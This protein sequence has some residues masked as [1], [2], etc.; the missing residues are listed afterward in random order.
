MKLL[1]AF[2][3]LYAAVVSANNDY[4]LLNQVGFLHAKVFSTTDETLTIQTISSADFLGNFSEI[5]ENVYLKPEPTYWYVIDLDT[6]DLEVTDQWYLS[7]TYYDEI[8]LY[9]RGN[10]KID[11]VRAGLRT[12]RD[13]SVKD[14]SDIPFQKTQ[15]FNGRYLYAKVKNYNNRYFINDVALQNQFS[16]N[17][18]KNH[19][20]VTEAKWQIKYYLFI[21]GAT[22]LF[23]YFI[24]IYFLYRDRLYII[25]S[26]YLFS[27]LLYIGAKAPVVSQVIRDFAPHYFFFYNSVIQIIVNILYLSFSIRFLNSKAEYPVLH[28]IFR[29]TLYFLYVVGIIQ[30]VLFLVNPISGWEERILVVERYYMLIFSLGSLFTLL[31]I[32]KKKQ[33]LFFVAGGFSFIIGAG[34]AFLLNNIVYM[35]IGAGLELFMFSIG[36]G[37][38]M[39]KIE[40]EKKQI[41]NEIVKVELSA[42]K[43]QMNPHFIF[44]SLNSIRAYVIANETKKASDYITKFSKLIRLML[45][46]SSKENIKLKEEI[47]ALQL[48]VQLEE[49]RFREGFGFKVTVDDELDTEDV[50]LPPLILQPY[51]ENAI[52]HGLAP[53]E[54]EKNIYLTITKRDAIIEFRIK[55]NGVGRQF[56]QRNIANRMEHKSIA[57]EL[58][59][60]RIHLTEKLYSSEENIIVN[61]LMENGIPA[62]TEVIIRLTLLH[63][64]KHK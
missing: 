25:Y 5:P 19:I 52:R 48:Y 17:F 40:D 61:D 51:I 39:K 28:K 44:N 59:Q 21:G 29:A 31:M 49:L 26:G 58:T 1:I 15:L 53:K 41:E 47:E 6:I 18:Y 43:A 55:D 30:V 2:F 7:F 10:G 42:L 45:H 63:K 24:G 34:M 62:G 9:L 36:L 64:T 35:I 14:Y 37:Y 3:L 46:Y 12:V 16:L 50:L 32:Y 8:V 57:M 33:V 54:G 27:L 23:F 20:H 11:S 22:I 4:S 60:R 38:R 56:H 13:S